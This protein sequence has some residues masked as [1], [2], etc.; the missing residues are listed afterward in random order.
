MLEKP[1]THR[2][3]HSWV[4][5]NITSC[6]YVRFLSNQSSGF[7][8]G[9]RFPQLSFTHRMPAVRFLHTGN[10]YFSVLLAVLDFW[11]LMGTHFCWL[12]FFIGPYLPKL[13][14]GGVLNW[15]IIMDSLGFVT[16]VISGTFCIYSGLALLDHTLWLRLSFYQLIKKGL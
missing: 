7:F 10:C 12:F 8:N 2:L 9:L 5:K 3:L 1:A 16:F 14:G 15:A 6:D 11:V 13:G 4:V